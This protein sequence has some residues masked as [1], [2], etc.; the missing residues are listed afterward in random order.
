MISC[1]PVLR[2]SKERERERER[3]R[4][5]SKV[6]V[7][8]AVEVLLDHVRDA[9]LVLLRDGLGLERR[10][11]DVAVRVHHA[12]QRIALPAED[13]IGVA[14]VAGSVTG[15]PEDRLAA[16]LG[17]ERLVVD[18]AGAPHGL[19][20]VLGLLDGGGGRAGGAGLEGAVLG[21][22]HVVAVVR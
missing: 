20:L 12:L 4:E 6:G 11:A 10:A 17:P 16:V 3:E 18:A 7:L 2:G 8:T 1:C 22:R 14:G 19:V 5:N 13:V 9:A 15:G 21:E